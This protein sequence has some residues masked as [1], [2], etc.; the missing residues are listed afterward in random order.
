MAR[1]QQS[2]TLILPVIISPKFAVLLPRL[3]G[4]HLLLVFTM[5]DARSQTDK[6]NRFAHVKDV[7][8]QIFDTIGPSNVQEDP[9]EIDTGRIKTRLL[10]FSFLRRPMIEQGVEQSVENQCEACSRHLAQPPEFSADQTLYG[11]L[12]IVEGLG[13]GQSFPLRKDVSCVGRGADQDVSLNYGD[14]YISR[15]AHVTIRV[16]RALDLVAVCF[17]DKPNAVLLDGRVLSGTQRLKH[18][19]Q[20]T[21]GRT[22]LRF[23][24]IDDCKDFWSV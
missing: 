1:L 11:W 23:F 21:I 14:E 22:V 16:D 13:R 12:V 24:Q 15:S 5:L 17:E 18:K 3:A 4:A 8:D 2:E 10:D 9:P 7:S 6:A 20:L 19:S